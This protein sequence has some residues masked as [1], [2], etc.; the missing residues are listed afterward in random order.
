MNDFIVEIKPANDARDS[1]MYILINEIFYPTTLSDMNKMMK[2]KCYFSF[3][4]VVKD[5]VKD[6]AGKKVTSSVHLEFETVHVS[7]RFYNAKML[8][9]LLN[10][11]VKQLGMRFS[12]EKNK[13][14]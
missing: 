12:L 2:E 8:Y 7:H 13:T 14:T 5:F 10:K 9:N 1:N 3:K 4:M 11:H 6:Q